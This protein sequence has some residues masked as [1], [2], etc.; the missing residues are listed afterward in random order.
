M[1]KILL[2]IIIFTITG[3]TQY[4]ELNE[5]AI[6]KS[7]G[8]KKENNYTLYAEIIDEVEKNNIPKTK[9]IEV[10]GNT[11]EE[12]FQNI[13]MFINKKIYFS[14]IDLIIFDEKLNNDDYKNIINY[15]LNNKEFR[16]DFLAI[17]S[18]NIKNILN[19]SKYDEIEKI[20]VTNKENKE[21]IKTSFEEIINSFLTKKSFTVSEINYDKDDKELKYNGNYKF[22]N[23][24]LER[25]NNEE[26]WI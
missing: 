25:I 19:N 12:L 1:K 11:V 6:I 5:L 8:I 21:I 23:S 3:C 4:S 22:I 10:T 7:I 17:T 9:I 15:F 24:K 13:N 26:N 18:N 16:N 14:H 2:L 20:I